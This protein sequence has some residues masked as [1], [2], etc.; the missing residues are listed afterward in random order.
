[1]WFWLGRPLGLNSLVVNPAA[2][3]AGSPSQGT[4][5]LSGPAPAG[6]VAVA[7]ASSATNRATVPAAVTIPAGST[8]A[9]FPIQTVPAQAGPVTI[10]ASFSGVTVSAQLTL[11]RL[12]SLTTNPSTVGPGQ[13][14]TG[15][16]TL[17]GPAPVAPVVNLVSANVQLVRVPP[18]VT[19]PAGSTSVNFA[20]QT[21]PITGEIS[22]TVAI[23]ASLAGAT[24]TGQL[25]L[26]RIT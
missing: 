4:V 26:I 13:P 24:V 23:T 17:S 15:T 2:V 20:I 8:S 9:N 21:T 25:A 3:I 14:S 10:T 18:A 5:T 6:G 12:V 16:L 22:T 1:M 11:V 19:I 7:L